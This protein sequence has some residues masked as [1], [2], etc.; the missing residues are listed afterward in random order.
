[1]RAVN[2][3]QTDVGVTV[4]DGSDATNRDARDDPKQGRESGWVLESFNDQM[5]QDPDGS[6]RGYIEVD[7]VRPF[8]TDEPDVDPQIDEGEVNCDKGYW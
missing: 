7:V 3:A 4:A 8:T 6:Y 2:L 5:R 1:M